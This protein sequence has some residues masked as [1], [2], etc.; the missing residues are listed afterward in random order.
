MS[1]VYNK[2][3]LL[4]QFFRGSP[5][6]QFFLKYECMQPSGSFKSRGIGNLILK[7][8]DKINSSNLNKRPQ[9]FSSSGGNAGLAAATASRRLSIP[10]T[11]VV[12]TATKERMVNKIKDTGAKVIVNGGHWSEAD[13]YLQNHVINK[14]D[15][16]EIEPIYVHPFDNPLIWEGH[17]TMIDEI[18]ESL[19]E[20]NIDIR[21]VK[22]ITCSI[23]GGGLYNG[24]IRGLE[25][26]NLASKIP[27]I[28]VETNGCQVFNTSL[29][30]KKLVKFPK[31]NTIAT[32]LGTSTISAK[33]FENALKY[34]TKSVVVDNIDVIK[35]CLR[36]TYDFNQ[37]AEPACGAALH[38][39][40][41]TGL[42]EN[43]LDTTLT[44]DDIIIVIACGGSSN[45]VQELEEALLK[46][47]LDYSLPQTPEYIFT[48]NHT[49][50]LSPVL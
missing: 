33:T 39:A 13:D 16:N 3:P 19:N 43:A 11:V 50:I 30:L 1:I 46:Y 9:V 24:L 5:I 8:I 48:E 31:I 15:L 21:N 42:I 36:Y 34:N 37:V 29:K 38:L 22:A 40:Y 35:T 17:S 28:G 18:I 45:T 14:I 25:K 26:Y 2:T 47:K 49:P 10:C 20:Q 32:S 12:P 41:N 6:P 44:K 4:R 23:G 27:I 7:S